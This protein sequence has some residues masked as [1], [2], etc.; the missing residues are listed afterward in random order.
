MGHFPGDI[1][2]H[3]PEFHRREMTLLASRNATA[4]EFRRVI[5]ALE[6]GRINA[7]AWTT[8]SFSPSALVE[9]F[10]RLLNPET[11]L[12]KPLVIW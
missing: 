4:A 1:T 11:G 7:G 2:F 6:E 9:A 8:Q 5:G 10:P 3:D 12:L